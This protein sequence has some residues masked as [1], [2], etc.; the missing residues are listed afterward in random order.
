MEEPSILLLDVPEKS[1]LPQQ[2]EEL[3]K[4]RAWGTETPHMSQA[5]L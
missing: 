2:A 1:V 4:E 3:W 5:F